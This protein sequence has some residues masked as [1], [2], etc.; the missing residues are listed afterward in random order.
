MRGGEKKKKKKARGGGEDQPLLLYASFVCAPCV[1]ASVGV[2]L[3]A[4]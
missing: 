3:S 1:G 2:L 4:F